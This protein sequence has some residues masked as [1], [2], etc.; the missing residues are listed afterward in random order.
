MPTNFFFFF[1][2]AGRE[3][4]GGV[5]ELG[6]RREEMVGKTTTMGLF[7]ECSR[8]FSTVGSGAPAK[9][10]KSHLAVLRHN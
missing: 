3:S 6:Q 9:L 2:H 7:F 10:P 5:H 1:N 4:D 8:A